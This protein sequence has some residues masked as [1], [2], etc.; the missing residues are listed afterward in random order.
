MVEAWSQ[1]ESLGPFACPSCRGEVVLRGGRRRIDHFAH[2]VER[3][4]SH[5]LGESENHRR[6]KAEIWVCLN[7]APHVADLQLERP[8]G[9]VRAN[10]SANINGVPVAIEVQISNLSL[11][12]IIRRTKE[13][14]RRGIYVLW[15]ARWRPALDSGRYSPKPWER[16]LHAAYFG[17]GY[18]WRGQTTVVPYHFDPGHVHAPARTW[19]D[20]RGNKKSSRGYSRRSLRWIRSVR[21]QVLNLLTDFN[22]RNRD[23]WKGGD[24]EIPPSKLYCDF[25]PVFWR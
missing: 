15:L 13:Y 4:C 11:A 20:P 7:D 18:Y 10:V 5:D 25:K 14:T 23:W 12:D 24:M 16:W 8:L 19:F 1:R 2:V 3:K 21:G 22:A 17:R 9:E 6:C